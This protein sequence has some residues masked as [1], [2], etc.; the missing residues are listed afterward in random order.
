MH[1]K[2]S[3]RLS[4]GKPTMRYLQKKHICV[5]VVQWSKCVWEILASK[6]S[7]WEIT[8]NHWK[9]IKKNWTYL[10]IIEKFGLETILGEAQ[11]IWVCS[12]LC[13]GRKELNH[14]GSLK[15][16]ERDDTCPEISPFY[17]PAK[18]SFSKK[19]IDNNSGHDK[20]LKKVNLKIWNLTICFV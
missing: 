3:K 11:F 13:A 7:I 12:F 18:H 6:Y 16:E 15:G 4:K 20:Y 1:D 14:R 8:N 10:N 9:F 17:D 19:N 2:K 5:N